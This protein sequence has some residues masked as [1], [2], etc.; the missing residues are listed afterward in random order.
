MTKRKLKPFAVSMLY[1]LSIVMLV[2][3]MY[4]IQGI[5]SN[6]VL[7]SQETAKEEGI[8]IEQIITDSDYEN[9]SED[10]P[11]VNTDSQI[12][13][14]YSD[15][16]VKIAKDYYD[17]QADATSQENS[18][19]YYENTYMQNSGIDYVGN[20]EFDVVSIL[21]GTVVSV[22]DDDILGTTIQIKHSN[23]LV[24]VYQSMSNVS[25]KEN[26]TVTQGTVIGKSGESN[27]GK[28]LG[29]HLHFELYRSGSIVNPEEYYGKLVGELS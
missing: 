8:D 3:S 6:N 11:V 19:I 29:N 5:I 28:D 4:F 9:N 13:R 21:D 14:P 23:D 16:S 17:Y 20:T 2:L 24:S 22:N 10:I 25:V 18:I 7:K 27:I 26:D 15:S 12:I 1:A